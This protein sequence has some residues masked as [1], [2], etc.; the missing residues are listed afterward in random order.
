MLRIGWAIFLACLAGG[1]ARAQ[2]GPRQPVAGEQTIS[3]LLA[4]GYE[5]VD[6]EVGAIQ[7]NRFQ[8]VE[9]VLLV[10]EAS[11]YTCSFRVER[12]PATDEPR[13]VSICTPVE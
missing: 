2:D 12:D 7:I 9:R 10:R 11:V 1:A 13:K 8:I 4:A 5:I 3:R 6:Y